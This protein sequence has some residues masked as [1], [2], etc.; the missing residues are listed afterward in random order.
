L[1]SKLTR[2]LLALPLLAFLLLT[3]Y[4]GLV[5]GWNATH[6][7]DTLGMKIATALQLAY[8]VLGVVGLFVLWRRP[9]WSRSALLGWSTTVTGEGALAPV[10]YAG[11]G[12]GFG[13][14]VAAVVAALT[15]GACYAWAKSALAPNAGPRLA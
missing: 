7:A 3:A 8:G 15:V 11:K 1:A 9:R 6:F 2:V 13:V 4:N 14:G 12:I 5:E 10:V